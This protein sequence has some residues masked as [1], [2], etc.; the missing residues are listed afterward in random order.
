MVSTSSS[1]TCAMTS[2]ATTSP[3]ISMAAA[4]KRIVRTLNQLFAREWVARNSVNRKQFGNAVRTTITARRSG[5]GKSRELRL[6]RV[7]R[8]GI[9]GVAGD[10]LEHP[11]Q[12]ELPAVGVRLPRVTALLLVGHGRRHGW[13][14]DRIADGLRRP[15]SGWRGPAAAQRPARPL[16]RPAGSVSC[17]WSCRVARPAR[18]ECPAQVMQS[19]RR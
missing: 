3:R 5:A 6:R 14:R 9:A 2:N 10:V 11:G 15:R 1:P 19:R 4:G 7:A 16:R 13:V 8:C 12:V 18:A 17:A